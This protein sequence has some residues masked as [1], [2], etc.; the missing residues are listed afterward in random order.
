[1]L[2]ANDFDAEAVGFL[3]D[4]FSGVVFEVRSFDWTTFTSFGVL[5]FEEPQPD[6]RSVFRE[7]FSFRETPEKL[8]PLV[9]V[10]DR[11]DIEPIPYK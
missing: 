10:V 4:L 3:D 5:F 8:A 1:M 2:G 7:V 9:D 6:F 11:V